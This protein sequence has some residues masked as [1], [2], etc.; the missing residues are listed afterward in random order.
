MQSKNG[1]I[2]FKLTAPTIK[3]YDGETPKTEYPDG[4]FVEFYGS[5]KAV[6]ASL[7][8]KYAVSFDTKNIMEARNNVVIIDYASGDTTYMESVVWD[9][10]EKKM[11][12]NQPIKSVNG[13]RITYGDGFESDEKFKNPQIFGQRGVLEL[14]EDE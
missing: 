14:K 9:K 5:D 4:V 3:K 6:S 10:N 2:Q 7:S 13:T 8:A 11:Y 12:S 1:N